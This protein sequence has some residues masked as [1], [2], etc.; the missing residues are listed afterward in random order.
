MTR[1]QTVE[2]RFKIK[3]GG[4]ITAYREASG[5]L[6]N[7]QLMAAHESPGTTKLY[8]RTGDEITVDELETEGMPVIDTGR[9]HA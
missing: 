3:L 9:Y 8:D 1:R 7:A 6:E 5:T 4:G 2:A